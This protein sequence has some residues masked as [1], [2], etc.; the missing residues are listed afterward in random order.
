[1]NINVEYL[2]NI[3]LLDDN[4]VFSIE[5]E[6][7]NFFYRFVKDLYDISFGNSL[8]EIKTFDNNMKELNC[9]GKVQV[10]SNYFEIDF[11]SKKISNALLKYVNDNISDFDKQ[12]IIKPQQKLLEVYN[13]IL[14]NMDLPLV[15]NNDI[16]TE[17]LGKFFKISINK[18][19]SL[20][21]NLFL[22]IDLEREL[23]INKL[24]VFINLKA[25]LFNDE[26]Y[27]LYKYSLYNKVKILLVDSF[28]Y[29][30]SLNNEKK[31]LIDENLDE[32]VL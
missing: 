13:K 19:L 26:L 20:L 31:L 6:N 18:P 7:K 3:I 30:V 23:K 27:E 14:N 12:N 16:S 25:Y 5:I 21:D 2:D 10:Y 11:D 8:E 9:L 24:L 22:L 1:M 15:I 4:Y 17:T 28:N 29:G 32:F